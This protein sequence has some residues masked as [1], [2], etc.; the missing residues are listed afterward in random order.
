[1][2]ILVGGAGIAGSFL[3]SKLNSEN[4]NDLVI[5]DEHT[6]PERIKNLEGK[7]YSKK[8]KYKE[9][10]RFLSVNQLHIQFVIVTEEVS[11][12]LA[13][14]IWGHCLE[15]GFP[16]IVLE[17]RDQSAFENL[18]SSEKGQQPYF[19][20]IVKI[21]DLQLITAAR[22]AIYFLMHERHSSGIY[23]IHADGS[24]PA[25]ENIGFIYN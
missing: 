5:A 16:L 13:Q 23:Q 10:S 7:R 4:F 6:D 8:I 18:T 20:S 12:E 11:K 15:F 22:E 2:I 21:E 24:C 14:S 9:L 25:L 19:W 3:A 17:R 1:M